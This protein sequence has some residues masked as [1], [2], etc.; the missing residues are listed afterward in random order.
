MIDINSEKI[1]KRFINEKLA[2][3]WCVDETQKSFEK[4]MNHLKNNTN[5]Y[6]FFIKASENIFK[7]LKKDN[8]IIAD[9]GGGIG[10]TGCIL[11]QSPQVK[12][13]YVVDPS[14]ERLSK[15][16]FVVKHFN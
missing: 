16:P 1:P 7:I 6:K 9:I 11:A 15:G 4:L 5:M 3:H 10:W 14:K 12:K 8:L 13:V 2:E